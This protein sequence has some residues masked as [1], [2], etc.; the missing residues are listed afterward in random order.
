MV[1]YVTLSLC[2]QR[3]KSQMIKTYTT[4]YAQL[5]K[6]IKIMLPSLKEKIHVSNVGPFVELCT[7]APHKEDKVVV[8]IQ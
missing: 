7:S 8:P 6:L 4:F 3:Y 5:K 2:Y 1:I